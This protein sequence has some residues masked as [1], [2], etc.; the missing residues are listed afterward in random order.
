M[1]S[2]ST[3]QHEREC[4]HPVCIQ[5][6]IC[7]AKWT[8]CENLGNGTHKLTCADGH[9]VIDNCSGGEA[10]CTEQ[11][12]CEYCKMPYGSFAL[13]NHNWGSSYTSDD[14]GWH[15]QVCTRD[16]NHHSNS[17]LCSGGTATCTEQATCAYCNTKYGKPLGHKWTEEDGT[18]A[19]YVSTGEDSH[20]QVCLRDN[21]HYK[22]DIPTPCS[23]GTATCTAKATCEYCNTLYGSI[24]PNNHDW[25]DY[26]SNG[27]G[28][29]SQV[30]KWDPSHKNTPVPCSGGTATCD[31]KPICD[32]CHTAYGTALGHDWGAW[33]SKNDDTH[34]R[35]CQRDPNHTDTKDC[36]GGTATCTEKAICEHCNTQ[37]GSIDENNHLW[38]SY[39]S[40]HD[41]THA[42]ICRR[43]P[44]HKNTAAPCSGGTATCISPAI[45]E[46]CYAVYGEID[47]DH[48]RPVP[49]PAVAPTQTETGLTEGTACGDCGTV[50][51]P[52]EIIPMLPATVPQT[53]DASRP[54][55]WLALM[56]SSLTGFALLARRRKQN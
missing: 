35:T 26:V 21:S 37:Y 15:Y 18:N 29:H 5:T 47:P 45:C 24:A 49:I 56:A 39:V 51:V 32:T 41:G 55:L 44:S 9:T 13:N 52:Q 7:E 54:V 3:T 1:V 23:G 14:K 16:E 50:L 48:H 28:T 36:S 25:G 31:D 8:K 42:Q 38:G 22:S 27:D 53:G 6:D 20:Y 10:T 17:V 40:N 2:G 11:A 19:K 33:V 30:C 4:T 34:T 43:E 12:I 46:H